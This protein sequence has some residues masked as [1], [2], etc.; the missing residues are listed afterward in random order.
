MVIG[1]RLWFLVELNLKSS[2]IG[3]HWSIWSSWLLVNTDGYWMLLVGADDGYWLLFNCRIHLGRQAARAGVIKCAVPTVIN[4]ID[5]PE[6]GGGNNTCHGTPNHFEL[7]DLD[8]CMVGCDNI[9]CHGTQNNF[10]LLNFDH[11]KV[12]GGN[13]TC[14]GTPNHFELLDLDH[15]MVGGDNI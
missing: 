9:S 1:W 3:C 12:G 2:L 5:H 8:H 4:L 7:L 11:P 15:C 10:A 6:V 14:H 13:N